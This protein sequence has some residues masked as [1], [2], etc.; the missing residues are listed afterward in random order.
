MQ[1]VLALGGLSSLL[2]RLAHQLDLKRLE[3]RGIRGRILDA[4]QARVKV[5]F[6]REGGNGQHTTAP[7]DEERSHRLVKEAG[8]TVGCFLQ[9]DDIPSGALG[10]GNLRRRAGLGH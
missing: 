1:H 2:A 7:H 6:R 8:V 5:D 9:D 10:G 4:H 3:N